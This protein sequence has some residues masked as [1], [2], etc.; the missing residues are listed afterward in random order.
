MKADFHSEGLRDIEVCS[1]YN[2]AKACGKE[3]F[4]HPIEVTGSM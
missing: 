2:K 1:F 3:F 4:A